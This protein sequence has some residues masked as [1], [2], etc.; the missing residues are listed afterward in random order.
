MPALAFGRHGTKADDVLELVAP[1]TARHSPQRYPKG[2]ALHDLHARLSVQVCHI[3]PE[4]RAAACAVCDCRQL[5][6]LFYVTGGRRL[7]RKDRV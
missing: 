2:K 3:C 7:C 6:T 5:T 1:R 4:C